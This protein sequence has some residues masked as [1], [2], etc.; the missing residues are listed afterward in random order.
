MID[1]TERR[2]AMYGNATTHSVVEMMQ[3]PLYETS[4]TYRAEVAAKIAAEDAAQSTMPGTEIVPEVTE[5]L[6]PFA[7]Q[8]ELNAAM[9]SERYRRSPEYRANVAAR[10]SI[11]NV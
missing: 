4:A 10:L 8:F 9:Q 1:H 11:S 3:N 7:D 6:R 2:T 5:G